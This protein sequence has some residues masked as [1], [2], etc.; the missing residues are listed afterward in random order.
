MVLPHLVFRFLVLVIKQLLYSSY[1]PSL[2]TLSTQKKLRKNTAKIVFY[3]N[4]LNYDPVLRD[5]TTSWG[6]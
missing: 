5:T 4:V 1:Q 2:Q 6:D 3:A